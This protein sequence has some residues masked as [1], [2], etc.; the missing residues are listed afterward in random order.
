MARVR[1]RHY[2][3]KPMTHAGLYI[4][5]L[6]NEQPISVN[7]NDPRIAERCIKVSREHCKFGKAKNLVVRERNYAKVFGAENVNFK[8]IVLMDEIAVAERLILEQLS[9]WRIRG[10]RG[11]MNEWLAGI[12]ASEV[13]RIALDMLAGS[14]LAYRLPGP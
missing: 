2:R 1:W 7:A 13:E 14:G 11:R 10:T 8:R 12:A 6:D 9:A 5:T 3:E 4:V